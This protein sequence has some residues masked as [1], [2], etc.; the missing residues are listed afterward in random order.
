MPRFLPKLINKFIV[1]IF[2]DIM[3]AGIITN[4]DVFPTCV[5]Y[6]E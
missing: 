5:V 3:L 4:K 1:Y 6:I 2:L